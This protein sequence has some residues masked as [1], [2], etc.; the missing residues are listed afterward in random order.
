M[1]KMWWFEIVGMVVVGVTIL[2]FAVFTPVLGGRS[3]FDLTVGR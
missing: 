1:K 3:F 2:T